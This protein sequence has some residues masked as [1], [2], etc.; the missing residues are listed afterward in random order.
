MVTSAMKKNKQKKG[1]ESE[2][3]WTLFYDEV[4][5]AKALRGEGAYRYLAGECSRQSE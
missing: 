1:I 2:S 4:R 5:C 3:R